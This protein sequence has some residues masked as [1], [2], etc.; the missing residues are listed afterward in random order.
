MKKLCL[1]RPTKAIKATINHFSFFV[2]L[3]VVVG[4]TGTRS[5][6]PVVPKALAGVSSCSLDM[7]SLSLVTV[8]RGM[9][10]AEF[11]GW[12]GEGCQYQLQVESS[13]GEAGEAVKSTPELAGPL[14]T[15]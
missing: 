2:N 15:K 9:F 3:L 10:G 5:L 11:G 6:G 12:I 7:T 4:S 1:K 13:K 14:A 8:L